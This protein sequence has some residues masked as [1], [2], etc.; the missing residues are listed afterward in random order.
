M[1]RR[2]LAVLLITLAAA[3]AALLFVLWNAWP[4]GCLLLVWAA[5]VAGGGWWLSTQRWAQGWMR[6]SNPR[7]WRVPKIDWRAFDRMRRDWE[8]EAALRRPVDDGVGG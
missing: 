2:L 5:T 6:S 3:F 8:R 7:R 4:A 1:T